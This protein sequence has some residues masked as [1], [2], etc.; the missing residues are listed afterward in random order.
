MMNTLD[1]A[2]YQQLL[3]AC[4]IGL[5]LIDKDGKV[6]WLNATLRDWLG[7]RA[8]SV[9][10][11]TSDTA[12][13]GLKDLWT[14]NATVH[15]AASASQDDLWLLGTSHALTGGGVMQ[16]FTDAT[17]LKLLMQERDKLQEELA[18]QSLSDP[19]T[20][21][22]NRRALSH[23]LESQVSR[24]RRYQNPLTIL[25]MRID[26]LPDFMAQHDT[27]SAQPL[28]VAIRNVLNDQLRWADIIGRM[29]DNEFLLI[30]PETHLDATGQMIELIT[31]RLDDLS[32]EGF[33]NSD[34]KVQARFSAA[35]W[36]KGDDVGL[37]MMRAREG[38]EG[39]E[40]QNTA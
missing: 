28:L 9:M 17:P 1:T 40:Q 21:M 26:N 13:P 3:E 20:G 32:I 7:T 36:H 11:H 35:E 31:Q 39:A 29:D 14:E 2:Q 34:F 19:D 10:Q 5:M 25:I 16:Y 15:L 6:Q 23:N 12:P 38:L 30:L 24:S 18:K 33:E 8:D 22:P 37:L 4:P 27:A